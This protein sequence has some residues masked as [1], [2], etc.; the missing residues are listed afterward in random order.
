M[1]LSNQV[2]RHG[3][4]SRWPDHEENL[5]V[6][7]TGKARI[8]EQRLPLG[9]PTSTMPGPRGH[10]LFGSLLDIQRD[11]LSFLLTTRRQFGDT[12]RV[13]LGPKTIYIISDPEDIQHVL[14]ENAR[15]YRKGAHYEMLKPVFGNGLML[16]EGDFWL[17]QRRIVQPAFHRQRLGRFATTMTSLTEE[18][19][20]HWDVSAGRG[21]PIDVW[22]EMVK[23]TLSIVCTTLFGVDI[24]KEAEGVGEAH[25]VCLQHANHRIVS[26][27]ALPEALPT[28]DN[29]RY[30]RSV[31][32]IHSVIDRLIVERRES[33]EDRGDLLSTL[34]FAR[35]EDTGELMDQ[36]QL[37]AEIIT[38]FLNGHETVSDAL[39][40]TFYLL[41]Q[42]PTVERRLHQELAAVL[43]GRVA[44][45]DDLP[46]LQYTS[47]VIQE[48]MRLFPPA[49]VIER[50]TLQADEIGGYQI[51]AKSTVVLS[52]WLTHRDPDHWENPEGFDPERFSPER[53]ASRHRFAYFPFGGGPRLCVGNNFAMME[54]SLL[55]ATIA[56]RY[57]LDLVSGH[58]VVMEPV[59]TLRPKHGI[60]TRLRR[61]AAVTTDGAIQAAEEIA[62]RS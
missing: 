44:T 4:N 17:K 61:R 49:W 34:A 25:S 50:D 6:L 58:P 38:L 35:Y 55:L 43:G 2:G 29:R 53:A 56:Q 31:G 51:P 33:G 28:P 11:P 60:L 12:V 59:I 5:M 7:S 26:L 1:A 37:R 13:R 46:K 47:W 41:S 48:S 27:F 32:L 8:R 16:S 36:A 40:W 57:H 30:H 52:Q 14:Q 19:L 21:R 23:L 15:N 10:L 22:R 20:G 24:S 54:M 39:G 45:M 9:R 18:M 62:A 42:Q 3:S